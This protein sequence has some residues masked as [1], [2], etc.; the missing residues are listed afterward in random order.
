MPTVE[1]FSSFELKLF[2]D[3]AGL[4]SSNLPNL[5]WIECKLD[6]KGKLLEILEILQ[7]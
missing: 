4:T 6:K 2:D 3:F 1:F 7:V 5:K